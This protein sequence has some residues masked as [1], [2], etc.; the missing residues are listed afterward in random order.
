MSI[1]NLSI[2]MYLCRPVQ[3]GVNKEVGWRA[4]VF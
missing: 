4:F 3:T 1:Y 2:L